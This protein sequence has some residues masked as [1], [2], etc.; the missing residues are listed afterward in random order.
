MAEPELPW[1]PDS[2]SAPNRPEV[3]QG[4]PLHPT[5]ELVRLPPVD[6]PRLLEPPGSLAGEVHAGQ[7]LLAAGDWLAEPSIEQSSDVQSAAGDR[8]SADFVWID[9]HSLGLPNSPTAFADPEPRLRP[10]TY[11]VLASEQWAG[12]VG[13]HREFYSLEGAT[14]FM[15]GLC[16]GAAMANSGFDE[17]FLRD[18][19]VENVLR[20]PNE[21][22]NE[23]LH[24]PKFLGEGYYMIPVYALAAL[25]EPLLVELP[26]GSSTAEWGQRSLR[27]ILV[28]APSMLSLQVIT[29][30]SRPL[31][32]D[33]GSYWQPFRD[34]NGVS[35]HSFMGA[36]PILT[37]AKMTES[38][39]L[40]GT[41]YAASILP[42]LSRVNDD[43]HYFSQA[44]LGWW[45]AY[46]AASAVDRSSNPDANHHFFLFSQSD[47]VGIGF[48]YVR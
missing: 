45:I 35:G 33:K 47:S 9:P 8:T 27:A 48:E 20:D 13:D 15:V 11:G 23:L 29:G 28:G 36:I 1:R 18:T 14:W 40:K 26:L 37:A 34:N 38:R 5:P 39:W 42:A 30:A 44:F 6:E 43:D 17:H 41:L 31:E 25:A 32:S 24:E 3:A 7:H 2:D 46:M 22:L 19:Y 12:M 21:E 16:G 10:I 4:A